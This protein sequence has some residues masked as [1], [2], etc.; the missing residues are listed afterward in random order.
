[1]KENIACILRSCKID[2]CRGNISNYSDVVGAY[3]DTI[4]EIIPDLNAVDSQPII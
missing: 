3:K 1:M 2:I 4:I